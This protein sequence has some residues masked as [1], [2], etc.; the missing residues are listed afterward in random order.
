M[1]FTLKTNEADFTV[2]DG[3]FAGRS[4]RTG[5]VYDVVPPQEAHKFKEIAAPAKGSSGHI[6]KGPN[7]ATTER[8]KKTE[9]NNG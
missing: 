4:F 2:V 9:V 3:P 8:P 7:D 1:S 5:A 6:I